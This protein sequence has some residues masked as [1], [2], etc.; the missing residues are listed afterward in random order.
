MVVAMKGQLRF[1]G[2]T[3]V[4]QQKPKIDS[5]TLDPDPSWWAS[6]DYREPGR[7]N[8]KGNVLIQWMHDEIYEEQS[9]VTVFQKQKRPHERPPRIHNVISA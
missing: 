2:K 8:N 1:G 9:H 4:V 5:G 3:R 7:P 6:E